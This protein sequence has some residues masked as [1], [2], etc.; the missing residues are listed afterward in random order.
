MTS[1]EKRKFIR[2]DSIHLLDYL[3]VHNNGETGSYSMGRTLDISLNGMMME[4]MYP[5]PEDISLVIT[6]GIENNLMDIAGHLTHTQKKC[7]R[8]ISGIEFVKVNKQGRKLLRHYVDIFQARKHE[9]LSRNDF[10]LKNK[11]DL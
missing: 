10:P 7:G 9:L 5:L 3:I 11:K 2:Q 8:F 4:T 1:T 6:L